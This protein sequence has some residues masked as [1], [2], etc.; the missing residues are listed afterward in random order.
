MP[1]GGW[2]C[3]Q[4]V[5]HPNVEELCLNMAGV[6]AVI[7]VNEH[8]GKGLF[9]PAHH[10]RSR[11]RRV[12]GGGISQPEGG[13]VERGGGCSSEFLVFHPFFFF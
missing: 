12:G 10:S 1:P 7:Y 11:G 3:P 8:W 2:L 13:R 6:Y 9:P 5:N 4:V